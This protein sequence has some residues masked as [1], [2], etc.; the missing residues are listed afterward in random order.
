MRTAVT[1]FCVETPHID[2]KIVM[3]SDLHFDIQYD[4]RRFLHILEKIKML[5]P[6]FICIPGDLID[7]VSV[8]KETDMTSFYHFFESLA[9]IAP[10]IVT[11][12]NHD[13]ETYD[14]NKG[15]IPA[16]EFQ[17]EKQMK[18]IPNLYLLEEEG[19]AFDSL[20]FYGLNASFQYYQEK[21][22]E[23][24]IE[25]LKKEFQDKLP[26]LNS[27][28]YNIL[29]FHSP[30]DL[31]HKKI[32]YETNLKQFDLILC[33][34][35]H[36]GLMFE[37]PFGNFGFISPDRKLFPRYIRGKKKYGNSTIITSSGIM[38]LSYSKKWFYYFN[39]LFAMGITSIHLFK[40]S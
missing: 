7:S 17:W 20:Y 37:L 39:D 4:D 22:K 11:L 10:T 30:L 35:T 32:Y 40:K 23:K 18:N 31:F 8:V 6:D 29:L 21:E 9:K 14:Q 13:I 24:K 26:V 25:R 27:N 12:G 2:K 28:R 33:G 15:W 3:I 38:K 16:M 36:N 1:N 5:V 34:H 19:I